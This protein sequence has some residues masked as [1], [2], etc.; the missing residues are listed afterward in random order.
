[1]SV[2]QKKDGRWFTVHRD[3][4][5]KRMETYFGRGPS[6]RDE[7]RAH[8]LEIKLAKRRGQPVAARADLH[9]AELGQ[10]YIEHCK[11]SGRSLDYLKT[12]VTLVNTFFI[13]FFKGKPVD[14]LTYLDD[15]T[16][17]SNHLQTT[18]SRH[19]RPRSQ[20]T[21]NRYFDYLHAI[22]TF[23]VSNDL[24]RNNPLKSWRKAKEQPRR[25][26]LTVADLGKI[27]RCSAPHLAWA[28][29]VEW[30]LGTRPGRSELF[31]LSWSDVD[32]DRAAITVYAG[33]TKTFRTIPL[34]PEFV[35]RLRDMRA[36]AQTEYIVE[37]R[38]AKINKLRSS[39]KSAVRRA[40]ITYDVRLYDVR[41]LFATVMLQGGADLAA[42]SRLMGHSRVTMTANTYYQYMQG[43]KERAVGLLPDLQTN[44][45]HVLPFQ[46]VGQKVGQK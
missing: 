33:K 2:H 32:F 15:M 41:H 8:D 27:I 40:G 11:M 13:P 16:R 3:D 35:E 12:L 6:G 39:F 24:I 45:A 7:A 44:S 20:I 46:K 23:G 31:A 38:G 29:E 26:L 28:I 4:Y 14:K 1:M 22:F 9:F 34:R 36:Q 17:L 5:G 19:N 21:V 10:S 43:E 30:N 18:P 42:V 25:I 37:Y